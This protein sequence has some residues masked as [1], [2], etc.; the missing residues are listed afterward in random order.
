MRNEQIDWALS[1]STVEPRRPGFNAKRSMEG[2]A[3][4]LPDQHLG[5]DAARVD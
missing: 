4:D 1:P 2:S 5:V 3:D